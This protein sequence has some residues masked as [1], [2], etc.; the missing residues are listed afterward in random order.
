[1][2]G[3]MEPKTVDLRGELFTSQLG[4][5]DGKGDDERIRTDMFGD[6]FALLG[7]DLPLSRFEYSAMASRRYRSLTLPTVISV[8]LNFY[9]VFR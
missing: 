6:A 5:L 7:L 1:M 4:S 8:I 3:A 2:A 9:G